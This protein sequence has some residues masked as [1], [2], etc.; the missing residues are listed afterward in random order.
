MTDKE[1]VELVE[2]T[3]PEELTLEQIE[4]IR[5]RLRSRPR[6][7][8]SGQLQIDQ[9]LAALIGNFEVS[10]E[11]MSRRRRASQRLDLV[12][13]DRLSADGGVRGLDAGLADVR[14]RAQR[15]PIA[16]RR[17]RRGGSG[18]RAGERR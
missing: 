5:G 12:G 16:S 10:P 11:L 14:R 18:R 2:T 3:M 8:F 15:K 9:Y 17:S 13:L 7:T 1:L 6:S 4:L